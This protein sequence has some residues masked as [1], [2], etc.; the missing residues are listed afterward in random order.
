[1][2]HIQS[3]YKSIKDEFCGPYRSMAIHCNLAFKESAHNSKI[4]S[5]IAE[6]DSVFTIWIS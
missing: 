3:P 1:M 6:T 5:K 2:Q 4:M